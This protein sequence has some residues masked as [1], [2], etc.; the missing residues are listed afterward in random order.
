VCLQ[1]CGYFSSLSNCVETSDTAIDADQRETHDIEI[2]EGSVGGARGEGLRRIAGRRAANRRRPRYGRWVGGRAG[3]AVDEHG[4]DSQEIVDPRRGGSGPC[5]RQRGRRYRGQWPRYKG[6]GQ[7]QSRGVISDTVSGDVDQHGNDGDGFATHRDVAERRYGVQR[8]GGRYRRPGLVDR[9]FV[10]QSTSNDTAEMQQQPAFRRGY[11]LRRGGGR[12]HLQGP[13][14]RYSEDT[15]YAR[16]ASQQRRAWGQ[17]HRGRLSPSSFHSSMESLNDAGSVE[18]DYGKNRRVIDVP[19]EVGNEKCQ[20][21]LYDISDL[22]Q[23]GCRVFVNMKDH[24]VVVTGGSADKALDQTVEL[25]YRKLVG[26][27]P[28]KC[29]DMSPGLTAAMS[30]RKGMKW[31]RELFKEHQ[32]PAVFYCDKDS[33]YVVAVDEA[34]AREAVDSLMDQIGTVDVPFVVSQT[35]FLMSQSWQSFAASVER[36]WIMTVKVMQSPVN[37]V[38]LVGVASQLSDADAMV[39]SQLTEKNVSVAELQM[40]SGELK[41]LCALLKDFRYM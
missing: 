11:Q 37:V 15:E 33:G 9:G 25:I 30:S 35:T 36:N 39:R 34:V 14:Q 19:N 17:P 29:S 38:R 12:I 5:A 40:S 27:Q 8:Q 28:V 4:I 26:M 31:I 21:L 32:K 41:Y 20:V 13:D 16:G 1:R 2:D 23:F 10:H 18:S 6:Q 7:G 3:F 22:K 24:Q